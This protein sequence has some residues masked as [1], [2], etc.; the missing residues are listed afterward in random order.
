MEYAKEVDIAADD[1]EYAIGDDGDNKPLA[2]GNDNEVNDYAST[3]CCA[4]S[5]ILLV[6]PAESM[7]LSALA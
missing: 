5:F 7:I 4:E 1:D 6:M 2:E 3:T